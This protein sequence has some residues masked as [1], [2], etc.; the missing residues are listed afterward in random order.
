VNRHPLEDVRVANPCKASWDAMYGDDRVRFCASCKLNVYNLSGMTRPE[1]TQLFQLV[2]GR[3]CVRFYRRTDGTLLT[4]D[5]PV[6]MKWTGGVARAASL[7]LWASAPFWGAW[8]IIYWK[9][10]QA[11]LAS[12]MPSGWV[13]SNAVQG[14]TEPVRSF[15]TL[16]RVA[17]PQPP[18]LPEMG[19]VA[20]GER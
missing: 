15:E 19:E 16:G 1:V 8:S 20:P 17:V 4:Q 11:T 9:D 10:I 5:C 18:R 14:A 3:L 2:E 12:W 6:G 13:R 7:V